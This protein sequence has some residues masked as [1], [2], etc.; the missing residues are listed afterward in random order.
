MR[1]EAIGKFWP[2]LGLLLVGLVM[3]IGL[4]ASPGWAQTLSVSDPASPPGPPTT[5]FEV[6]CVGCHP[7]GGNIIRRGK[8]LK[9]RALER[10]GYDDVDSIAEIITHGKGI[11]SAYQDRLTPDEIQ[12]LATYVFDQAKAGW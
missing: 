3:L 9:A 7:N 1:L 5:L 11:M 8:T 10:Y 4:G 12:R 6:H 2:T